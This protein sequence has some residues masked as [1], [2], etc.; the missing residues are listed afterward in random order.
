MGFEG[1]VVE[2]VGDDEVGLSYF[3]HQFDRFKLLNDFRIL[4]AHFIFHSGFEHA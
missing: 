4:I 2:I 1:E 3:F